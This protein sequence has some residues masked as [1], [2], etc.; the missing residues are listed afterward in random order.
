[1]QDLT[2]MAF[3]Q[4]EPRS[5]EFGMNDGMAELIQSAQES[6]GISAEDTDM[7]LYDQP[8]PNQAV[9]QVVVVAKNQ[10]SSTKHVLG[11]C[12]TV[13]VDRNYDENSVDL[14]IVGSANSYFA[15]KKI[16]FKFVNPLIQV[17][18]QPKH[19]VILPE[20]DWYNAKYIVNPK[21]YDGKD[22][23]IAEVKEGDVSVRLYYFLKITEDLYTPTCQGAAWVISK[24]SAIE[25]SDT[26]S[27]AAWLHSAELSSLLANASQS[28]TGFQD[29][30]GS[31]VGETT[32]EGPAAQIT[33]DTTAAGHNWYVDPTP[34]DNLV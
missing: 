11:S 10:A 16:S 6:L 33:L 4:A 25:T 14:S 31:A 13:F 21:L 22:V 9:A 34:L 7:Y 24:D 28:L 26:E 8:E 3:V 29:L 32:G 17:V 15:I 12:N 23:V 18:Q 19:G 5:V 27:V 1:M 20:D 2:P 30:A